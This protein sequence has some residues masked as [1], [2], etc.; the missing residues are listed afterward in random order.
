MAV[1]KNERAWNVA[2]RAVSLFL[3]QADAH[4]LDG[5]QRTILQYVIRDTIRDVRRRAG[6]TGKKKEVTQHAVR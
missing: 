6:R 5:K 2:G 1:G 3:S 4:A